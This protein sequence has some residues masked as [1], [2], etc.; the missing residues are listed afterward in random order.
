MGVVDRLARM[1]LECGGAEEFAL[2]GPTRKNGEGLKWELEYKKDPTLS[3][4]REYGL[5]ERDE[6]TP[7]DKVKHHADERQ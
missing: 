3:Y 1:G 2:R 5:G 6:T 4:G 7:E